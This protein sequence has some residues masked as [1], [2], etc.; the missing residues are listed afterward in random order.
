MRAITTRRVVQAVELVS[1]A[2]MPE[3]PLQTP[4]TPAAETSKGAT[5]SDPNV[6]SNSQ[7]MPMCAGAAEAHS[8]H[9]LESEPGCQNSVCV[10]TEFCHPRPSDPHLSGGPFCRKNNTSTNRTLFSVGLLNVNSLN[11]A[12]F[13]ACCNIL[14]S[15]NM[16]WLALTELIKPSKD[17]TSLA[18]LIRTHK[19]YPILSHQE[20]PRVGIMIPKFLEKKFSILGANSF[21]QRRERVCQ[22]SVK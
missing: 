19:S 22:K 5:C 3:E 11:A 7:T 20:C 9:V 10:H 6:S 1:T 4:R 8:H 15:Q 17:F 12:K 18:N 16:T 13:T 2:G 14:K 21:L